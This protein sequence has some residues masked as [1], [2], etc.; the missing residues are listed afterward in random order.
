MNAAK[1]SI[2]I[3][4]FLVLF[5]TTIAY[6]GITPYYKGEWGMSPEEIKALNEDAP[7]AEIG[8]M[9]VYVEESDGAYSE[10]SYF[11]QNSTL[12]GTEYLIKG[13]FAQEKELRKW[14]K[15]LQALMVAPEDDKFTF[16]TKEKKLADGVVIFLYLW[17]NSTTQVFGRVY[18]N[19]TDKVFN[20]EFSFAD[21]KMLAADEDPTLVV[22]ALDDVA[23][24]IFNAFKNEN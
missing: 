20:L 12:I 19:N 10:T 21:L 16:E 2:F 18:V 22:N 8:Q 17:K 1:K 6:A 14:L 11:F 13:T 9:L 23:D 3:A 24:D 5:I 15:E 4:V 7:D